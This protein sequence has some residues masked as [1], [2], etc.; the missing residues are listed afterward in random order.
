MSTALVQAIRVDDEDKVADLI[1]KI[2]SD[3][4]ADVVSEL[5]VV[6]VVPFLQIIDRVLRSEKNH[7]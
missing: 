1:S 2:G 4:V 3:E 5:P 7:E 6:H